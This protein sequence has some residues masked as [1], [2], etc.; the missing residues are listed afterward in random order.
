MEAH[1]TQAKAMVGRDKWLFVAYGVRTLRLTI[2][3]V[4]NAPVVALEKILKANDVA[5]L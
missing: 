2:E 4:L 5:S 3:M 1:T